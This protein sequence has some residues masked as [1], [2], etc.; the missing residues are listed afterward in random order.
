MDTKLWDKLFKELKNDKDLFEKV[1]EIV[2]NHFKEEYE[3][4]VG[5]FSGNNQAKS[6]KNGSFVK[7]NEVIDYLSK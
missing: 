4:L 2:S 3:Y 6:A 5:N 1:K 7:N